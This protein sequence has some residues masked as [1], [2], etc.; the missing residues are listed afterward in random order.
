MTKSARRLQASLIE[1][2]REG[3]K[4]RHEHVAGLGALPLHPTLA[5]RL[6]FWRDLFGRLERLANRLDDKTRNKIVEAVLARVPMPTEEERR[7]P[8]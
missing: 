6:E 3:G 1:T 4:V 2:R 8:F 5:D 7:A